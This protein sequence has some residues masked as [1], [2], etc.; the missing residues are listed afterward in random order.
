MPS[1]SLGKT[2]FVL[3]RLINGAG[4]GV[5]PGTIGTIKDVVRGKGITFETAK[6]PC[7]GQFAYITG[8]NRSDLTLAPEFAE[9]ISEKDRLAALHYIWEKSNNFDR[10]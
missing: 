5:S 4:D 6:C 2:V 3:K 7:C 9:E 8:V 1:S 10:K